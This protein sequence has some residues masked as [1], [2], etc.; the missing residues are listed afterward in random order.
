MAAAPRSAVSSLWTKR[1]AWE[2]VLEEIGNPVVRADAG[3]FPHRMAA[4]IAGAIRSAVFRGEGGPSPH[5]LPGGASR[6]VGARGT[7]STACQISWRSRRSP[8]RIV[9][10]RGEEVREP[11]ADSEEEPDRVG[12]VAHFGA[13]RG[14]DEH[15]Q[16]EPDDAEQPFPHA[17]PPFHEHIEREPGAREQIDQPG[18]ADDPDVRRVSLEGDRERERRRGRR[19][20]RV[21][22]RAERPV[23][24]VDQP[25]QEHRVREQVDR[26]GVGGHRGQEPPRLAAVEHR[27]AARRERLGEVGRPPPIDRADHRGDGERPDD[28]EPGAPPRLPREHRRETTTRSFG[29][30]PRRG[31]GGRGSGS[32]IRVN[33]SGSSARIPPVVPLLLGKERLSRG[34]FRLLGEFLEPLGPLAA[35][36]SFPAAPAHRDPGI[37][38]PPAAVLL[39]PAPGSMPKRIVL[40]YSGG[41]DTSCAIPW[42]RERCDAEVLAVVA[43][44]R[45]GRGPRGRL[46]EGRGLRRRRGLRRGPPRGLR[47]ELLLSGGAGRRDLRGPLPARHLARPPGDREAPGRDRAPRRG[48]RP[49]P[50]LHRQGERPGALR[51]RLPRARSRS[52]GDRPLAPLGD[53]V[54]RGCPRLRRPPRGAGRTDRVRP[55]QPRP[56]P[57]PPEPRGRGSRGS[58]ERAPGRPLPD[59]EGPGGGGAGVRVRR[60]RVRGGVP[61][62]GGRGTAR[63]GGAADP[64]QRARGPARGGPGRPR[65]EPARRDEVARRVRDP[66]RDDPPRGA[67]RP[68]WPLPRPGDGSFRRRGGAPLRGAGV[69]REVVLGAPGSARRLLRRGAPEHDRRR[70]RPPLPGRRRRRRAEEPPEASTARTSPPSAPTRCTARRTPRG[71]SASSA[72]PSGSGA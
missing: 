7:F 70:P 46:G 23:R 22:A 14:G 67:R 17:Q 68:R 11:E 5:P 66:R 52:R 44:C 48:R 6:R 10:R 56:E 45:P 25:G 58:V 41:L 36:S 55:L 59:H 30:S 62:G 64:A 43:V 47:R 38:R 8:C 57:L 33:S 20:P 28:R 1:P 3:R 60:G 39:P 54:A 24:Q 40:A 49:R 53:P 42:L 13:D 51:A 21:E 12:P 63:P 72:F 2:S 31:S 27:L 4:R 71:S 61:G 34:G 50:R 15:D 65:R 16:E 37:L 26:V 69:R 9:S 29:A 35:V 19:A 32:P 18:G